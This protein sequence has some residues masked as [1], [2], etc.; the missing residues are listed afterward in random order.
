MDAGRWIAMATKNRSNQA[1]LEP[2]QRVQEVQD[3]SGCAHH[4]VIETPSGPVSKGV[5][6]VCR[7][8]KQFQNYLENSVWTSDVSLEQLAR[9]AGYGGRREPRAVS[10]DDE[11]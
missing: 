8:E 11:G 7:M 10:A 6:R 3:T 2:K 4:W 1:V 9:K 5:C